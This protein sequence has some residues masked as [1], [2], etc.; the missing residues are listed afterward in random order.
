M[1]KKPK[2]E[3]GDFDFIPKNIKMVLEA[4]PKPTIK[5]VFSC[6]GCGCKKYR[7]KVTNNE[8]YGPGGAII[9]T[10]LT[11]EHCGLVHDPEKFTKTLKE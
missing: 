11:C 5:F 2:W 8:I 1:I 10:G 7:E 9:V 4:S 3:K 6:S